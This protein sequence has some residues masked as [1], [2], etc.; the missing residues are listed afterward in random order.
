[1]AGEIVCMINAMVKIEIPIMMIKYGHVVG[2][3][4]DLHLSTNIFST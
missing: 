3:I 4:I 1:M 2:Q